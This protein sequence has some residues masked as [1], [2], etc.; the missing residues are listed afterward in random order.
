MTTNGYT[1]PLPLEGSPLLDWPPRPLALLRYCIRPIL[2]PWGA[3]WLG[4]TALLWNVF[5]PSRCT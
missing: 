4:L 1:P 5:T 3:V 2:I